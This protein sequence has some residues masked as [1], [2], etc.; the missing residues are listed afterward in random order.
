MKEKASS[1]RRSFLRKIPLLG[2]LPFIPQLS[3]ASSASEDEQDT[4]P[5]E[6]KNGQVCLSLFQT[7]DVHCQIHPHDEMFWE[8]NEK[9]FRL[10]YR[11]V[12]KYK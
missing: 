1:S 9:V 6:D 8:N 10:A 7:T 11:Y 12:R 2:A 3:F 5:I 4:I